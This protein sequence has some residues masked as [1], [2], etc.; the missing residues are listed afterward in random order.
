MSRLRWTSILG[1]VIATFSAF[2]SMA[3]CGDVY[4]D[5]LLGDDKF[6][7]RV[8]APND[9]ANGPVRTLARGVERL[10]PGDRLILVD[11]KTIFTGEISLIGPRC[12]GINGKPFVIEGN[13]AVLDGSHPIPFEAWQQPKPGVWKFTPR[14][15]GTHLLLLDGQ[16]FAEHPIPP[17]A[18]KLPEIPDGT[19]GTWHGSIYYKV[20]PGPLQTPRDLNFSCAANGVG[21]TLLDVQE[22][23]IRNLKVRHYRLDG[24]N[25]HDRCTNVILENVTLEQNGRAGLAAGGS[26]LVGLRD[27]TVTGNRVTQIL[28][29]ERAQVELLKTTLGDKPG[30][31]FRINGG[32]LLID[33]QEVHM[34]GK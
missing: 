32:H 13:N 29:A 33:Q 12:S 34:P 30:T 23:V 8:P 20:K 17:G 9:E 6:N 25:A 2:P 14:R 31:P 28:V 7:G 24:V 16:P 10:L 19:W 4:V 26:S 27:C 22:V 21:I 15:K 1:L 18:E 3:R 11:R 5:S